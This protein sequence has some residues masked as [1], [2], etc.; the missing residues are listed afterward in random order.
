[1]KGTFTFL[2][3]KLLPGT[4]SLEA[5]LFCDNKL[6]LYKNDVLITRAPWLGELESVFTFELLLGWPFVSAIV[7][8]EEISSFLNSFLETGSGSPFVPEMDY[9]YCNLS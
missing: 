5:F 9:W 4:I 1:V 3:S 8:F 2:L 6:E 7:G